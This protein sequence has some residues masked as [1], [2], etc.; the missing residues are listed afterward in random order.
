MPR[1]AHYLLALLAAA[2]LAVA[3]QVFRCRPDPPG[4]WVCVNVTDVS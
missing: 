3:D 4:P 1:S 2:A